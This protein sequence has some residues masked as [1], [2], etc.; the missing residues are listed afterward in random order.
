VVGSLIGWGFV[1]LSMRKFL[2]DPSLPAPEARA[3]RSLIDAAAKEAGQ[4]PKLGISLLLSLCASFG[5]RI[6]SLTA[7]LVNNLVVWSASKG[8]RSFALEIPVDNA[9]LYLGIGGL[10]AL[11]TAMLLFSGALL[12]LV[13]DFLLARVEAGTSLE[14][15]F[16]A[17]AMRWVGGGAMSVAV[18]FSLAKFVGVRR[19]SKAASEDGEAATDAS[20]EDGEAATDASIEDPLLDVG[21]S[22]RRVLLAAVGLGLAALAVW[23]FVNAGVNTFSVLMLV[24]I[25]IMAALMVPLG[26][27]LSLQIGSSSS[28]TSGTVFVTVLVLCLVALVTNAA[29]LEYVHVI[30]T[31][32]VAASVAVNSANDNSQ[33]YKTMQ[34]CGVPPRDGFLAQ[35]IGL[36]AGAVVVPISLY[37]SASAFGLGTKAL[38]APQGQ[39][40]ATLVDGLLIQSTVP[41]YPICIGLAVGALA[42]ALDA[43]GSRAGLQLPAM[44]LCVGI[45]LRPDTG[46]GI[47]IGSSF[48]HGGE[49]WRLRRRGG[50]MGAPGQTHECMLAAAGL[51]T[52][53]AFLDLVL[54]VAVLF[55]LQVESLRAFSST[56]EAAK[57]PIPAFVTNALAALSL[58]FLG[59]I[60]FHN[61]VYGTLEGGTVP[62]GSG[63]N[64]IGEADDADGERSGSG[65]NGV[66]EADV[67]DAERCEDPL[68]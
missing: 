19:A 45:Y 56:G 61:S 6:L 40:F 4:R 33:D 32:L 8:A 46:I 24:A 55:N 12:R 41:W 13:G 53:S 30:T 49:A 62:G 51:I 34:L 47:L 38:P 25:V 23:L 60:L 22:T 28:P 42:V 50:G 7:I 29:S 36:L 2:S 11:P 10:L 66:G 59:W 65:T 27:I 3:C 64:G 63:T 21:E 17:N 52:G 48:R 5:V 44:A 31:L 67:A 16:P 14:T 9:P 26:A 18:V 20:S 39:M 58:V 37:I 35:L 1:G 57:V 54:G 43:W 68:H 15:E